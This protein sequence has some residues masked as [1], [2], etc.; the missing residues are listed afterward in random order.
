MEVFDHKPRIY[1]ICGKAQ[2][3]KNTVGNEIKKIY[4]KIGKKAI[5][6]Q[7]SS[8]IKNYA[9]NIINW[10][11]SEETKPR[12]FL[13]KLG[14]ELIKQKISSE[15][16]IRRMIEDVEVYSYFYDLIVI[17]DARFPEEIEAIKNKFNNVTSIRVIRNINDYQAEGY[18]HLTET[19]LDNYNGYDYVIHNDGS[20]EELE[21]K[22]KKLFDEV[23]KDE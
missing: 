9:K 5:N 10:D 18:K 12:A 6:L 4:E 7:F 23:N 16:L 11:G 22:V 15:M 8:Y 14:V 17:N 20:K 13:Q 19:A 1:V 21:E 2:H 3:G